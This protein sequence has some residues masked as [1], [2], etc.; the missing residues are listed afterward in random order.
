MDEIRRALDRIAATGVAMELNTS[1]VNKAIPEMNPFPEML[2][3]IAS[4]EIPVVVGAD[5]HV[6]SRV[7]DRF[8]QGL[9][10][11][12]ECGFTHVSY[13]LDR[14]R[15]DV[16]IEIARASLRDSKLDDPVDVA[17]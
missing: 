10:L 13:F 16:N 15:H 14:V 9:D 4:R 5:A 8:E 6:P 17:G 11:L 12:C 2:V 1:G 3:E 7:A